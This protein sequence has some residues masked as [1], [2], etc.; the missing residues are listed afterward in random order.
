MENMPGRLHCELSGHAADEGD[1]PTAGSLSTNR[2]HRE[3]GRVPIVRS[4]PDG[5]PRTQA[6]AR[7]RT[8]PD[9]VLTA[10][11]GGVLPD[12][13][14]TDGLDD[15]ETP[16]ESRSRL[17]RPSVTPQAD[18]NPTPAGPARHP[19]SATSCRL[20]FTSPDDREPVAGEPIPR[21]SPV[22]RRLATVSPNDRHRLSGN[23]PCRSRRIAHRM[24]LL[25]RFTRGRITTASLRRAQAAATPGGRNRDSIWPVE[26]C[27]HGRRPRAYPLGDRSL[28]RPSGDR[29]CPH[30]RFHVKRKQPVD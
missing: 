22:R 13:R 6:R 4:L 20:S 5:Q 29:C 9:G 1:A 7:S 8:S 15:G 17:G 23:A 28:R 26:Q 19:A 25:G 2:P 3:Q 30:G 11:E 27:L 12:L 16:L 18:L 10:F 14:L 21:L 24:G